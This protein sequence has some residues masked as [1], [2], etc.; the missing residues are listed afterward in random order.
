[1]FITC[2]DLI[3]VKFNLLLVALKVSFMHPLFEAS[4]IDWPLALIAVA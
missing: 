1:M 3:V 2:H 4:K